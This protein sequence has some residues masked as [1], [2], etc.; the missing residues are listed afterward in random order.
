MS[1]EKGGEGGGG[2]SLHSGSCEAA[3]GFKNENLAHKGNSPEHTHGGDSRPAT[4][5]TPAGKR[6]QFYQRHAF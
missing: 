6:A 4:T 3:T 1:A 5:I 2:E